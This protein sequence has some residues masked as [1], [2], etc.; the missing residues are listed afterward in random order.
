MPVTRHLLRFTN[1][2]TGKR[3]TFVP[4]TL[5]PTG[6]YRASTSR[7][8]WCAL[9]DTFAPLPSG[10][11]PFGFNSL[12]MSGNPFSICSWGRPPRPQCFTTATVSPFAPTKAVFFCGTILAVTCTGNYPASLVFREPGLSSGLLF[13]GKPATT[14]PTL[15]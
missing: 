14:S 9:T 13:S 1:N 11:Q 2:G 12:L 4:P 7:Y 15:S 3:P 5:L 10:K 8:C 6:V